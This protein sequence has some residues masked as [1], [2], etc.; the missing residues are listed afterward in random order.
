MITVVVIIVALGILD[1]MLF[2]ACTE[3]EKR[4]ERYERDNRKNDH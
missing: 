4:Q 3:L 1:A 2:I